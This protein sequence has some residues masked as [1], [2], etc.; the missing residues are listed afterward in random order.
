VLDKKMQQALYRQSLR[1]EEHDDPDHPVVRLATMR[2]EELGGKAKAIAAEIAI[3][4]ASRPDTPRREDVE[5]ALAAIPDL[6]KALAQAADEEL[7]DLLDS[8]DITVTYHKPA[9]I[10]EV[11]ALLGVLDPAPDDE[12][13]PDEG[14]SLNSFIAGAQCHARQG[15]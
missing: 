14:P 7:V 3:L 11:S 6:R 4:E 15:R 13:R 12:R 9:G 5:A 8:F 10:F 1:L 2:I